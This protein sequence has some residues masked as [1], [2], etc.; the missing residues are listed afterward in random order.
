MA[1]EA[2]AALKRREETYPALVAA[3][4]LDAG[5]AEADLAAWREIAAD[6]HWIATGEDGEPDYHDMYCSRT[7]RIAA[8]DTAIDRF[9]TGMDRSGGAARLPLTARRQI[10]R[11]AAM[12]WWAERECNHPESLHVRSLA[13]VGHEWRKENGHLPLGQSR[14]SRGMAA[15]EGHV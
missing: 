8:L 1:S 9:F 11:L 7:A 2:A 15:Q 6:W 13:W 5:A 12:R 10:T 14:A 4:K 3:G